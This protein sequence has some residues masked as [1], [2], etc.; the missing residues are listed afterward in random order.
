MLT[1]RVCRIVGNDGSLDRTHIGGMVF[2]ID[3]GTVGATGTLV[4]GR[5]LDVTGSG[6]AVE[7]N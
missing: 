7:I 5:C 3:A 6:V 1:A 4:A 2:V